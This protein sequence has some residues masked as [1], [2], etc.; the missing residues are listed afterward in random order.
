V[1]LDEPRGIAQLKVL[2]Q[3]QHADLV[4]GISTRITVPVSPL[5]WL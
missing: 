3:H 5:R 4:H 1:L 2:R